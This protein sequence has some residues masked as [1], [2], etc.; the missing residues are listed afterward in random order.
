[1][2]N[3]ILTVLY[4]SHW[5]D[6]GTISEGGKFSLQM[7]AHAQGLG[8]VG[9]CSLPPTFLLWM[10]RTST[11]KHFYGWNFGRISVITTSPCKITALDT[12]LNMILPSLLI[13]FFSWFDWRLHMF[14]AVEEIFFI[15]F[16]GS[17]ACYVIWLVLILFGLLIK[18]KLPF[19]GL[20]IVFVIL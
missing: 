15:V 7:F 16:R 8:W 19:C 3:W 2:W 10:N 20:K 4:I 13:T 12:I 18:E 6:D 17:A 5:N 11:C 14:L 1:M 9:G